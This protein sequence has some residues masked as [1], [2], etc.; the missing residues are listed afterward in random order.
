V[1]PASVPLPLSLLLDDPIRL[2]AV[3]EL[4]A[5]ASS[6]LEFLASFPV[7]QYQTRDLFVQSSVRI[8]AQILL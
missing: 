8:I 2:E 3:I 7:I 1:N 6:L 4:N 5:E